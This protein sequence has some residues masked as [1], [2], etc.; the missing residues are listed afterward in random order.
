MTLRVIQ[1]A[2]GKVGRRAARAI[3]DH[4]GLELIGI[5]A[6]SPDKVGKDAGELCG[7][8]ETGVRA[9]DDVEELLA[10]G[11]DCVSY[12]P[13]LPNPDELERILEA[14]INVVSTAG[15]ITGRNV[16]GGL[17]ERLDRA[18]RKGGASIFGGGINPGFM[19]LLALTLT[20]LCDRVYSVS[21]TES[22]DVSGYDSAGIWQML[23]WGQPVGAAGQHLHVE[24]VDEFFLDALDLM[25][26]ALGLALDEKR[27][28]VEYSLA[29]NDI[30]LPFMTFPKDT[31]AGQRSTWCGMAGGRPV[32]SLRIVWQM[33]GDLDPGWPLAEGYRIE[34][35]GEPA[36]STR[37]ALKQPARAELSRERHPMGLAW[38]ATAMPVVNAIPAVCRA[39]PGVCSYL[40]L[41]LICAADLVQSA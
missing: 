32:I 1:W 20:G 6:F 4:P 22:A 9:T 15:F 3:I 38:I 17:Y 31:V 35:E 16:M 39:A 21:V 30:V 12:N 8:D 34:I 23:G 7:T 25:A 19:N 24:S 18:A 27:T 29:R 37:V 40:D 28:Q 26:D 10:L 33:G 13:L 14:G 2:T 41:P 36:I 5:H 11:A